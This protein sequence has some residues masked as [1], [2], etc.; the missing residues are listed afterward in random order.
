MRTCGRCSLKAGHTRQRLPR[1]GRDI[2][3]HSEPFMSLAGSVASDAVWQNGLKAMPR[4]P[5]VTNQWP[6]YEDVDPLSS[7]RTPHE[8]VVADGEAAALSG[9]G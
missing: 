7:D 2:L 8:A 9:F 6:P 4:P 5:R 1:Q 3:I